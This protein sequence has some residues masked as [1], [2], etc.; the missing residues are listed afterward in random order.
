MGLRTMLL[1]LR[2]HIE[3]THITRTYYYV[4]LLAHSLVQSWFYIDVLYRRLRRLSRY[5]G[6]IDQVVDVINYFVQHFCNLRAL[7]F[8]YV[9][10][11]CLVGPS[12][13]VTYD[14]SDFI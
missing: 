6:L 7:Y 2:C 12:M 13:Y 3:C 8:F 9:I 14:R 11:F 5:I 10:S 1:C 4:S